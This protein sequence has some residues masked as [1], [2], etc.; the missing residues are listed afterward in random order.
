MPRRP[1]ILL[2]PALA[3]SAAALLWRFS[4]PDRPAPPPPAKA[5]PLRAFTPPEA[6]QYPETA[7][8]PALREAL[9]GTP[10]LS[11]EQRLH[12]VREL[13]ENPSEAET[14]ALLAA[15]MERRPD[16]VS[17]ALFSSYLHEIACRLQVQPTVREPFARA[18]AT[19]VR[20]PRRD[21]TSRD[22]AIQHLRQVW[23]RAADNP[24][25][26]DAVAATFAGFAGLEPAIAASALLSLHLLGTTPAPA[27]AHAPIAGASRP[28]RFAIPDSEIFPLLTA[29]FSQAPAADNLPARLTACRIA[30]DRRLA[31]LR[32]PLLA[33]LRNPAE[34]AMVRMAAANALGRIA[35]P[36]DLATLASYDPGDDRVAA[37]LQ[38]ALRAQPRP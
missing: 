35:D 12:L 36:G 8:R 5:S 37:A 28:T 26:R 30:G 1:V 23:D 22:Y 25:L 13:P 6:S 32:A 4:P 10:E 20:D 19:L 24:A 29:V 16:G 2:I 18:L 9:G 21:S 38:Y 7:L 33:R 17:T 15:L 31:G 27:L 11:W 14:N 3:L 34:H